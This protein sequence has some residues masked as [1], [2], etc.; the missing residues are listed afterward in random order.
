MIN[1]HDLRGI[2]MEISS[3]C[4]ASCPKCNRNIDGGYTLPWLNE[5]EMSLSQFKKIITPEI[6]ENINWLNFCGNYGDPGTA[7]ELAQ[8]CEYVRTTRNDFDMYIHTNGGMKS[9]EF[10]KN[11]SLNFLKSDSHNSTITFSI[12][13]LEDTNHIYRRGV[14]WER[15]IK[16]LEAA[17]STGAHI[18]WEFLVFKH[19]QHQIDEARELANTMGVSKFTVK[20]AMGFSGNGEHRPSMKVVDNKG[21][22]IYNIYET[23]DTR[24]NDKTTADLPTINDINSDPVTKSD[25]IYKHFKDLPN[26]EKDIQNGEFSYLDGS[27]IDCNASHSKS[28]YI[29]A[30]GK[31]YPCC[32]LGENSQVTFSK[33]SYQ[34]DKWLDRQGLHQNGIDT[35]YFRV[36]DVMKNENYFEKIRKSWDIHSHTDPEKV[37]SCSKFCKTDSHIMKRIY[38]K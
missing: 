5:V 23:D 15:V 33:H 18:T 30:A 9:P 29:D 27:E 22:H 14:S 8:I 1:F 24:Y 12:D 3:K 37:I 32:F 36:K 11:V 16:N 34:F 26:Y 35:K 28:I 17:I 21:N 31:V 38:K 25:L 7:T 13:G 6:I 20:T 4:N 2:Q 19:N 10:W